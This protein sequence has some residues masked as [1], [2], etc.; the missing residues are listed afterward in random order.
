[1]ARGEGT[2]VIIMYK[3]ERVLESLDFL[4]R[5]SSRKN[6]EESYKISFLTSAG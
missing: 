6:E 1:M 5:F 4:L 3:F 2:K